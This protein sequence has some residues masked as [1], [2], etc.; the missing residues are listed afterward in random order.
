MTAVKRLVAVPVQPFG[1]P[2]LR[3][4]LAVGEVCADLQIAQSTF[5]E[6]RTK[7]TGPHA[8]SCPTGSSACAALTLKPG[9][10]PARTWPDGQPH[11]RRAHLEN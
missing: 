1:K 2:V 11:L 10:T 9:S 3:D 8:S 4:K 7:G 5:Y 6:W